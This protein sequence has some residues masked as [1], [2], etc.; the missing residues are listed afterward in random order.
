ML[1]REIPKDVDLQVF[2]NFTLKLVYDL[3]FTVLTTFTALFWLRNQDKG[4]CLVPT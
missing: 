3:S 4:G 1:S 2:H